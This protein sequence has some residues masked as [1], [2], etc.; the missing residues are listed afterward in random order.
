[1][2]FFT[3]LSKKTSRFL[4]LLLMMFSWGVAWG[5]TVI[6]SGDFLTL[7]PHSYTADLEIT[8]GDDTWLVSTSQF[9]GGVFYLGCNS[10]NKAKGLLSTQ[11]TDVIE[12]LQTHLGSF[13]AASKHAY[14]M[15]LQLDSPMQNVNSIAINWDGAN[16]A[17]K[18]YL[19]ADSGSGLTCVANATSG[20][21]QTS[22]GS[23]SCTMSSVTINDLVLVAVPTSNSKTL[24]ITTYEILGTNSTN[25]ATQPVFTP[26]TE[27][28]FVDSQTITASCETDGATIHYTTNGDT[29]TDASPVFPT[30]GLTITETTTINAIAVADGMES[31]SVVTAT[32][33]KLPVYTIAEVKSLATGTADVAVQLTDAVVTGVSSKD[34][35]VQD[36]TGGI[37]LF[38]SGKSYAV[39]DVLNGYVIGTFTIYKNMPEITSGDY[40]N[41]TA[42]SGA[43][44]T[45]TVVA[46]AD[47]LA[48]PETYYCSLIKVEDVI[49]ADGQLSQNGSSLTLYNKFGFD[50]TAYNWP[51]LADVTGVFAPYDETMQLYIRNEED[52]VNT[53]VLE[54]PD[55]SWSADA[56]T[57]DVSATTNVYP[58]F[59]TNSDGEV[60]YSSSA[61]SVATIAS[62]GTITLLTAG[63]TVIT[64]TVAA[65]ASYSAASASYTLTV[66]NVA[67]MGTPTVFVAEYNGAYYAMGTTI[68]TSIKNSIGAIDV[69]VVN[70][71]VINVADR[72]A[73]TWYVDAENGYIRNGD[74]NYLTGTSGS[75]NVSLSSSPCE[76][77]WSDENNAWTIEKR[78]MIFNSQKIFKNYAYSNLG[79]SGYSTEFT[80]AMTFADGY[81]RSTTVDKFGTI[82]LP[83]AV[84]ADDIAGAKFYSVAGKQTDGGVLKG[85]VLTEETALQ[86]GVPYIFCATADKLVVAYNGGAAEATSANG[87]VGTLSGQDV[88]QGKHILTNNTVKEC[89]TGCTIGANR[90]YFDIDAMSEF[91]GALGVNQRMITFDDTETGI[92]EV[93]VSEQGAVDVYTISGVK[94]RSQVDASH[95]TE[96]LPQGIYVVNGKKVVVR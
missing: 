56:C 31:S 14:A 92:N 89:G 53:S 5:Q 27:T 12:A 29:P 72:A 1:M 55:V 18:V 77:T 81:V 91:G 49:Y 58:E 21:T 4:L 88:A 52:I 69:D 93:G 16:N 35:F 30:G 90:A 71:K 50:H 7:S 37:D 25:Q 6:K 45:P 17:M 26:A 48:N 24:R 62:D 47:L 8:L 13:A 51:A 39:G 46:V 95:A 54:V 65:S 36:A 82:C 23:I 3:F 94:V 42:V 22:A 60:T 11:W 79:T 73:I 33:T 96:A 70:G 9:Q 38:Q 2:R 34:I 44:A 87:L 75:T 67:S 59:T 43:G 61:E 19:F 76:W 32:Y 15:R 86:A 84:A 64:A 63:T 20:A 68:L 74:G 57:A 41:V 40:T 80:Q 85:I 83:C 10:N 78:S 66:T 28:K